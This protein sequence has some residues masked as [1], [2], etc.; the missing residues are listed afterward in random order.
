MDDRCS[1]D[2]EQRFAELEARVADLTARLAAATQPTRVE[3]TTSTSEAPPVTSRRGALRLAGA[4]LAGVVGAA[5]ISSGRAAADANDPLL[6]GQDQ[7]DF[8]GNNI[9]DL[10]T[11][12]TYTGQGTTTTGFLFISA[13]ESNAVTNQGLFGAA[14][15]G[16]AQPGRN[17]ANGIYGLSQNAAGYGV[18]GQNLAVNGGT[19]VFGTSATGTGVTGLT[20]TGA[21]GVS[22]ITNFAEGSGVLGIG[23]FAGVLGFSGDYSLASQLSNKANLYLQPNNNLGNDVIAKKTRPSTRG[24]EHRQGELENVDGDLWCCV[25]GG[26]PGTWRKVSGPQ[27]AGAYHAITPARVYDSRSP[28]PAPGVHTIGEPRTISLAAAR[29]L[30]SGAVLNPN[31]VPLGATAVLA[32]VT[33]ANTIGAGF[34]AVNPGGIN[35]VASA[36]INWSATGQIL[37]NG[38]SLTL[39][40]DRQVTIVPGGSVGSATDVIIDITGYFL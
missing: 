5:A 9:S 6:L 40:G 24:D 3:H 36:T 18:V 30:S 27:T 21:S 23:G 16:W 37:N 4:A 31:L 13:Q 22:G 2:T 34:L 11:R 8:F 33:V 12:V 10:P 39:G 17:I 25:V 14:L 20:S 28:E 32:N 15:G 1:S 19:G 35:S 26:T 38:V 7:D 29:D